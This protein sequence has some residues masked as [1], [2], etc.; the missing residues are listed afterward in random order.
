MNT[1]VTTPGKGLR[2]P[3][4]LSAPER[5]NRVE[6][7]RLLW[8]RLMLAERVGK[9]NTFART[10]R[11]KN[12]QHGATL[13]TA[14]IMLVVMTLLAVSG[15]RSSSTNLRIAGNMQMQEEA[16]AAAQQAIE[17][18]LSNSDFTKDQPPNKT[19]GLYTVEFLQPVCLSSKPVSPT[20]DTLPEDCRGSI[21][22]CSWTSWEISAIAIDNNSGARAHIYQGV[23][24]LAG[25]NATLDFC[26]T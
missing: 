9:H 25:P 12:S 15:I 14:L 20:E 19:I 18:V 23:S 22:T 2:T 1:I 16:S 8:P 24:V 7:A 13:I 3:G 26:G 21:V 5:I 11:L 17:E 4:I 10:T 6:W